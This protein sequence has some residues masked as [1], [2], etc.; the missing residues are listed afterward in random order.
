[1]PALV[2]SFKDGCAGHQ[3]VVN[4]KALP[5]ATSMSKPNLGTAHIGRAGI[6]TGVGITGVVALAAY[7]S[8]IR[9][10]HLQWGA[11]EATAQANEG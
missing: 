9:P 6:V 8:L 5:K 2:R 3:Y 11:T 1:M 4:A 10:W 7:P